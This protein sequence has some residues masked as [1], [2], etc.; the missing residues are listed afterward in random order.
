MCLGMVVKIVEVHGDGRAVVEHESVEDDS[1]EKA[2]RRE[3]VLLMTVADDDIEPGDW[4]VIHSGFA[5]ERIS[6]E[7]AADALAIRA[8]K[9]T[10]AA[11]EAAPIAAPIAAPT[12]SHHADSHHEEMAP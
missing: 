5:L 4:V 9:P 8:T 2:G 11:P 3:E 12:D 1:V 6:A 10:D 7:H